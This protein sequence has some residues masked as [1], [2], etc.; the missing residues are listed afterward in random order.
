MSKG[1]IPW[2]KGKRGLQVAWNKGMKLPQY[3]GKNS[4][5][6]KPKIKK[7]SPQ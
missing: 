1:C 3:S 2:N 7:I 4:P 6:W 5:V